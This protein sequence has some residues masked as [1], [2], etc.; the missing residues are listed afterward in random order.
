MSTEL[1]QAPLS[2]VT[3]FTSNI[4][5]HVVIL[6]RLIISFLHST[7]VP[8]RIHVEGYRGETLE[9]A[10]TKYYSLLFDATWVLQKTCIN[11]YYANILQL[12]IV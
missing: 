12:K 3:V 5:Y 7:P 10:T 8:R 6:R 11:I 4:K 9:I 2:D 1:F